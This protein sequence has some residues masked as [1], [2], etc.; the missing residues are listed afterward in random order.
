M[1]MASNSAATLGPAIGQGG[2]GETGAEQAERNRMME[3]I[4]ADWYMLRFTEFGVACVERGPC[5]ASDSAAD[6][7]T[8]PPAPSSPESP[9]E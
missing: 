8:S 9:Q 1:S 4:Y 2:Q 6:T 3:T 5:W 7:L